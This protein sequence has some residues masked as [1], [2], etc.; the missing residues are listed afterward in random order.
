MN[1]TA[2]THFKDRHHAGRRLAALL[3][4][5]ADTKNPLILA[6][7]RGGVPVA[8]EI[9]RLLKQP[10]DAII[11]RKLGVPSHEEIAMGAI[12]SGGAQVLWED[13]IS[14]FELTRQDVDAVILKENEELARLE[15][16]YRGGRRLP[17]IAGREVI[18]VDDG[19]ATGATITA[20][21]QLLRLKGAARIVVAVP[22]GPRETLTRLREQADEVVA[23]IAPERLLSVGGWY[24]DFSEVSDE[25]VQDL[26]EDE[27]P[28]AGPTR[29]HQSPVF[30][31]TKA[32][33]QQIRPHAKP[34]TG[35]AEDFDGLLEMIG[36]SSVVLLGEA[37]H[38][39][40]EFY[41]IR[42][43]ITKRLIV[44]KGFTAVAV[45]ADWPDAY[46]VNRHVRGES[47]DVTGVQ[48]LTGF[49]RF[50]SW[51]WR[52]ADVLDFIAWLREHNENVP[53]LAHEVGFYG[54][55][56]YSLH[57]SMKEVIA[58]LDAVD[59]VEAVKARAFY[60]CFDRFG[61]DPQDYGLFAGSGLSENCR[62]DVA[63]Q[64]ANLRA[65]ETEYLSHNDAAA[66]ADEFFF[67]EQNARLVI[68]AEAY[69]REMFRSGGSSWNLRDQHMTE[70]LVE[71]IA[72]LSS[73]QGT[74]KVV[75]WA[76]NSHLGDA[77][78]TEM[79]RRGELNIGQLVRDAFPTQS[80]LIGFTT[81]AGTVTAASGWHL[82][83]E[84]MQV[85]PG[86]EGSY[87][88]LFHQVGP[89]NFWLDLTQQNAAVDVLKEPRL[90]RAIGV[91]YRPDT[92]RQ[93][94]YFGA[95]L[96]D[97]FDAVLHYDITRAVEPLE[98]MPEWVRDEA[99]E[100][101]PVGL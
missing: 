21:I 64:L 80:K 34:L 55:D 11:V 59:P 18:V 47:D 46:R 58:Y 74:A 97:Q 72:H 29:K 6:L 75:V 45:E 100:T 66:S 39:T 33:L 22:V 49:S 91:V 76:H 61:R 94:H 84:R 71:L 30:T 23:A 98:H 52:N 89:P 36:D 99:P 32:A 88:Q 41:K 8:A 13:L 28:M 50:P 81:Y 53:S 57:K 95:C 44:E 63:R 26:L 60:G 42:A 56:L 69:Y 51:M 101:F 4:R 82:P 92:E 70:T 7:P 79:S 3:S 62:E 65:K 24:D 15:E 86:M 12:A 43:E 20:A 1:S 48:A 54:L 40:H 2:T 83:P 37:S 9:A 27:C 85:R 67:A 90:E 38:G 19:V 96:G 31:S 68:N 35:A 73:A 25:E 5:Y 77:R 17:E 14:Q 16:F 78:A 87:E 93:S 10:Y